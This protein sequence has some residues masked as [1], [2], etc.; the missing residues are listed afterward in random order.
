MLYAR[1]YIVLPNPTDPMVIKAFERGAFKEFERHSR[2]GMVSEE[3]FAKRVEE[4][5]KAGAR[6]DVATPDGKPVMDVSLAF[7]Y[8]R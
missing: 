5:R 2:V 7:D 4:L 6:V 8:G 1:G 3:S